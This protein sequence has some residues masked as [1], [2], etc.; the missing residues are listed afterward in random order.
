M[1]IYSSSRRFPVIKWILE[2]AICAPKFLIKI[3]NCPFL[4]PPDKNL[5]K[6]SRNFME[7][8]EEIPAHIASGLGSQASPWA[9]SFPFLVYPALNK[10]VWNSFF[11]GLFMV[12]RDCL[13]EAGYL[14]ISLLGQCLKLQGYFPLWH[15]LKYN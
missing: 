1:P 2:K 13:C 8:K 11:K 10:T 3:G 7:L 5:L 6:S 4:P 15:F 12:H 14:P 9:M